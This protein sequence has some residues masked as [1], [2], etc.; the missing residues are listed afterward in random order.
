M[1]FQTLLRPVVRDRRRA[2]PNQP[3]EP[4]A[5]KRALA[6]L[7]VGQKNRRAV[8]MIDLSRGGLVLRGAS[9]TDVFTRLKEELPSSVEITIEDARSPEI[10]VRDGLWRGASLIIDDTG[11]ELKLVSII[12]RIPSFIAKGIILIASVVLFSIIVMTVVG[13]V[14]GKLIPGVFGIGGVAG[15][16]MFTIIERIFV[17]N[18][19]GAW[20]PELH[21]AIEKI[22]GYESSTG[23]YPPPV[24]RRRPTS[25]TIISWILIVLSVAG[26]VGTFITMKSS[27]YDT[28]LAMGHLPVAFLNVYQLVCG[29]VGFL[30]GLF[31]L[32]GAA[33]ARW[34]YV[35]W[36]AFGVLVNVGN[37]GFSLFVLPGLVIYVL[38]TAILL[39]KNSSDFFSERYG[40]KP[41]EIHNETL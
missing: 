28:T 37:F 26:L 20:A 38:L 30:S 40:K 39:R 36:G 34:L 12:H 13:A 7:V 5:Q 19:R 1:E 10:R 31:M 35:G 32:K 23:P 33:W 6:Q 14:S 16:A 21:Q 9:I 22:N 4:I 25:I 2:T 8:K 15:F 41:S 27:D 24:I 17:S 3:L 18:I 29:A 11:K